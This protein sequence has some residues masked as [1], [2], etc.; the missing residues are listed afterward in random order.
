MQLQQPYVR[1]ST[2]LRFTL[3]LLVCAEAV[4]AFLLIFLVLVESVVIERE[5]GEYSTEVVQSPVALLLFAFVL[6]STAIAAWV[7][8]L[9]LQNWARWL[10]V[11]NA[12]LGFFFLFAN[13]A[14]VNL[15]WQFVTTI[16]SIS[17]ML[18]GAIVFAIFCS[19]LSYEFRRVAKAHPISAPN[20]GDRTAPRPPP[21]D[22]PR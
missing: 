15:R 18:S 12:G 21:P 20:A 3:Q 1:A 16:E 13:A 5:V 14:A 8:L 19:P 6:G 7:G 9:L 17:G 22:L 4:F 2:R 10:Y 11:A